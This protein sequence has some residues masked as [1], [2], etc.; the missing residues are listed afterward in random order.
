MKS[1]TQFSFVLDQKEHLF[2][3]LYFKGFVQFGKDIGKSNNC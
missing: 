1:Y 2:I 3:K